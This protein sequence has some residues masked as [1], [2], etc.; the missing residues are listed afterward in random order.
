MLKANNIFHEESLEYKNVGKVL[1]ERQAELNDLQDICE[2]CSVND[3]KIEYDVNRFYDACVEPDVTLSDWLFADKGNASQ[4]VK[5]YVLSMLDSFTDY[6][7]NTGRVIDVSLGK[8]Q[9]CA[10]DE[11]SYRDKRR[12]YLSEMR[13]IDEFA[14]F[15]GS[16]FVDSEFSEDVV[17]AMR[18]IP[19]FGLHTKEIV[20]NLA[21]LNDEAITI[22]EK[23][24]K[25]AKEAMKELASKAKDCSGDP[26]HKDRLKFPFPYEV[27]ENGENRTYIAEITCSPHLKLVRRDSNLR[28]YFYWYD[29]RIGDG[30]KV[31]IGSIGGHPY[32][33]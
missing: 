1:G 31:L 27:K 16:C 32:K 9:D 12:N 20:N 24:Q 30:K 15:M 22:Y 3:E 33:N 25:N 14:A 29:E 19:D 2:Y 17:T 8:Y 7:E 6:K 23:H 18:K 4:D 13:N 28:I 21:L 26:R 10:Y 11:N 5:D